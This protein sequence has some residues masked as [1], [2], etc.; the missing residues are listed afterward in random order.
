MTISE[1]VPSDKPMAMAY[2]RIPED[3]NCLELNMLML[4]LSEAKQV[5]ARRMEAIAKNFIIGWESKPGL[6]IMF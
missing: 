3:E 5:G 4:L 6:K 1:D 2:P